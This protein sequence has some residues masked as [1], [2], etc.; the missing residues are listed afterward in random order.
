MRLRLSWLLPFFP[1]NF[2]ITNSLFPSSQLIF[3]VFNPSLFYLFQQFFSRSQIRMFLPPILRQ[4]SFKGF[5]ED[6]LAVDFQLGFRGFEVINAVVQ[7][8]E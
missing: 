8:T 6:G 7:F 3:I 2:P 1:S 4:F 5:F